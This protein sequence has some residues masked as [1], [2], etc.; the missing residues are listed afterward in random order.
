[1]LFKQNLNKEKASSTV[2]LYWISPTESD[3]K[4]NSENESPGPHYILN[5]RAPQEGIHPWYTEQIKI[6]VWI[7]E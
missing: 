4:F 3:L 7:E 2:D 5:I 1:M 6:P